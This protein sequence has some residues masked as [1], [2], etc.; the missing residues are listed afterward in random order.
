MPGGGV[1]NFPNGEA[2][3]DWLRNNFE[4]YAQENPGFSFT[5]SRPFGIRESVALT[6][7]QALGCVADGTCGW[8]P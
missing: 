2:L 7:N 5:L 3:Y 8:N 1:Y 4:A 6:A